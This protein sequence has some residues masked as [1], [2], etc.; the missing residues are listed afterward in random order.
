MTLASPPVP[1][2]GNAPIAPNQ[3]LQEKTQKSPEEI[4]IDKLMSTWPDFIKNPENSIFVDIKKRLL[5]Q[6]KWHQGEKGYLKFYDLPTKIFMKVHDAV[7]SSN[8][9]DQIAH[10]FQ[11]FEGYLTDQQIAFKFNQICMTHRDL[12]PEFF[13]VVVPQVKKTLLKTD[14]GCNE[15]LHKIIIGAANIKL[16]DK[17]IW[18]LIV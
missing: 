9:T 5:Q 1:P 15:T 2:A 12:T 11:E 18:D 14:R 8:T 13:D 4:K 17:E 6:Y 10:T 3:Q 16:A 7:Y